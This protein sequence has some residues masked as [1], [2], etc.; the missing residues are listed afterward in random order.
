MVHTVQSPSDGVESA[1]LT[2]AQAQRTLAQLIGRELADVW[3][4]RNSAIVPLAC[5]A[6]AATI[7]DECVSANSAGN[8][9]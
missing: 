2:L 8:P 5:G 7:D 1:A 3:L 4:M 9:R 6:S